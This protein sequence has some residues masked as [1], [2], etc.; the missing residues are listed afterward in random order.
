MMSYKNYLAR[1]VFD[2]ERDTFH[3]EVVNVR[4]VITFQGT[5]V[6]ELHQA[7]IDSVEDY[8]DFC[9]S[10]GEEPDMPFSGRFTIYLSPEQHRQVVFAA[11]KSGKGIDM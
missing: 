11:E 7:F 3:G 1:I 9:Q 8:L 2:D 6:D 10:R 5:S 4:D